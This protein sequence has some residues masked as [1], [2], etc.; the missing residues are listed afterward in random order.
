M[1]DAVP[2]KAFIHERALCESEDVGARTR[3]WAFAHVM[4]DARIGTDCNIGGHAF[5]ESG[6]VV[7]DGVTIKNGVA[8]WEGVTI[9]DDVFV[10]PYAVFTNDPDPRSAF[11]KSRE[12]FL[13]TLVENGATIGANST[14]MCG[15]VVGEAAFVGAGAVVVRDVPAHAVV[16]GNPAD[17]IGSMCTCGKRL[18]E[19]H[20]CECGRRYGPR[21]RRPGG[22]EEL[23]SGS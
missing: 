8:I 18:N 21:T 7:G 15:I 20:V 2:N 4:K 1:N 19:K 22:L 5:V 9:G 17:S 16:V 10:G 14:I 3:V 23:G 6:A 12:E 13:P 11:K